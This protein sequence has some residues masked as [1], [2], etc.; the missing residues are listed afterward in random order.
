MDLRPREFRR[1]AVYCG[2]SDAVAEPY[3]EAAREFGA[4]LARRGIGVIYGGGRV[5]LMGAVADA[6][7]EGGGEVI[8]VITRKLIT[9]EKGHDGLTKRFV[10]DGMSARKSM[11]AQLADGFVA[12]PGGWGTLEELFEVATLSQLNYFRKPFGFFNVE[13]YYDRLL[14]FLE[15]AQRE[16][17]VR[18]FQA[19]MMVVSDDQEEL[20]RQLATIEIPEITPQAV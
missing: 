4:F 20:L 12:L 16:G 1:I 9:L 18:P 15:H 5:G 17:F 7:L 13:G 8:G 11:M 6:A 3:F 14:A 2:S 10:V 19:R